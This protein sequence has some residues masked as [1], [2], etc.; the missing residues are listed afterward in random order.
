M[1]HR[2]I[3]C[4]LDM[5]LIEESLSLSACLKRPVEV[6]AGYNQL[7]KEKKKKKTDSV[8]MRYIH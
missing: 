2:G 7:L 8:H 4:R 5:T 1:A 3:L 6:D